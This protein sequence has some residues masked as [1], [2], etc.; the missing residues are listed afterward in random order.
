MSTH[1]LDMPSTSS[2]T[3]PRRSD[4]LGLENMRHL[5]MPPP[6]KLHGHPK[7]LHRSTATGFSRASSSCVP[8]QRKAVM[9]KE[10]MM[11]SWI[12]NDESLGLN[13]GLNARL[14][15]YVVTERDV[16]QQPELIN[17][18]IIDVNVK[19]FLLLIRHMFDNE[20]WACVSQVIDVKERLRD[21]DELL[22]FSAAPASKNCA[23]GMCSVKA[24][25]SGFM[26][27]VFRS[28][29]RARRFGSVYFVKKCKS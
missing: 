2:T 25:C 24:A 12:L 14:K 19:P 28:L 8:F 9:D 29:K 5:K 17:N 4:S 16:P 27:G 13:V 20:A 6:G 21:K 18:A 15:R 7:N 10:L 3:S 11:L 23:P 22:F 26:F 1:H